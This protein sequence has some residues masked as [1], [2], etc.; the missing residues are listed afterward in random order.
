MGLRRQQ[1]AAEAE[2]HAMSAQMQRAEVAAERS[3]AQL[4]AAQGQLKKLQVSTP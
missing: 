3:V 4:A 1:E 2:L